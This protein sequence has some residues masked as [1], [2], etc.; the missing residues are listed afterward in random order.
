MANNENPFKDISAGDIYNWMEQ[1]PKQ[2]R[3]M[4]ANVE[5]DASAAAGEKEDNGGDDAD[6]AWNGRISNGRKGGSTKGRRAATPDEL[7]ELSKR[8]G[9]M[10]SR[11]L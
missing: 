2:A 6:G 10:N 7:R 5:R 1:H 8:Y 11:P 9:A 3:R 4:L